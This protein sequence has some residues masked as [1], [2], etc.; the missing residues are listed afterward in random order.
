MSLLLANSSIA[1]VLG[2]IQH[3]QQQWDPWPKKLPD[4][5]G[6][7]TEQ[8]IKLI[9]RVEGIMADTMFSV[10]GS[11]DTQYSAETY[12]IVAMIIVSVFWG[13]WLD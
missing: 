6:L 10:P 8:V 5:F 2:G 11:G 7:V 4:E 13:S 9:G 3:S 12:A 1:N